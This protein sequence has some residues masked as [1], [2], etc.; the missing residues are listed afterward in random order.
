LLHSSK[1][2]PIATFFPIEKEKFVN[3]S[4]DSLSIS[5]PAPEPAYDPI[6]KDPSSGRQNQI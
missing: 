2:T 1:K 5:D 3:E 4:G 6:T